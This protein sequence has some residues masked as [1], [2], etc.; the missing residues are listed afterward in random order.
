MLHCFRVNI[1]RINRVFS[2]FIWACQWELTSTRTN[3]FL[4]PLA[5]GVGLCYSFIRQILPRLMFIRNQFDPFL[6]RV[7]QTKLFDVLPSFVVSTCRVTYGP[8]SGFLREVVSSCRFLF[9]CC[10]SNICHRYRA[11][12]W[13]RISWMLWCL[14][15]NTGPY[16]LEP[17]DKT[18]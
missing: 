8:L 13:R 6:R 7:I 5:G 10:P 3:I 16:T 14:H 12:R 15:P 11:K 2:V 18:H 1:Q 4:P 9:V 17:Q